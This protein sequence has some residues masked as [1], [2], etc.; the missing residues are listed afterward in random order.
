LIDWAERSEAVIE[1]VAA[2]GDTLVDGS[3]VLRTHGGNGKFLLKDLM[4]AVH[5][6]TER[7]FTQD[8]KY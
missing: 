4:Q 7:T 3:I 6:G 8:P 5:L 1:M 2:V